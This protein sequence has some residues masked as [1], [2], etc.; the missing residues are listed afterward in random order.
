MKIKSNGIT[1]EY[2]DYGPVDAPPVILIRGLGSQLVHWPKAFVDGF[3]EAGYRTI[4][5]DNRDVGLSQRCDREG[6]SSDADAILALAEAGETPSA[7]YLLDDMAND[8]VGLMDA[9][10]IDRAHVF[11]IS[12]GGAI[13]QL[14]AVNHADRLRSAMLVMTTARQLP[15]ERLPELLAHSETREQAMASWLE[16]NRVYGSPGYP[17]ADAE[18][19]AE[20]GLA[21]D[22]G[23]DA[24]GIN[25]QTLAMLNSAD[26]RPMLPSIKLPCLIIHGAEDKIL[27][28]E[29][30]R[31]I[32]QLMPQA[33]YR[34]VAGMGHVISP[35]L[36]PLLV[37]MVV[38]FTGEH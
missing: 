20:A 19:L 37:K 26:R 9:L 27:A 7:S 35:K 24:A 23:Q 3:V 6:V 4:I 32:A 33:L 8:V 10:D 36:S 5:F 15:V 31:E 11:G 14:L 18:V 30:G 28:P 16:Y 21:F 22:R 25:R 34:E 1:L 13:S 2:E 12:M 29:H 38:E 17:M